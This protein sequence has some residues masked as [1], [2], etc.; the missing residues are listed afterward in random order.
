MDLARQRRF[1]EALMR[2]REAIEVDPRFAEAH[3]RLGILYRRLGELEQ[4]REALSQ[5]LELS[6]KNSKFLYAMGTVFF[7][8][9]EY[10]RAEQVFRKSWS[11]DGSLNSLFSLGETLQRL[12]RESQAA[13]AWREYL[14][15]DADSV[16]GREASRR[17]EEL[18]AGDESRGR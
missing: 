15:R 10:K 13:D 4:A 6:P 1:P 3:A 12:G 7:D 14:R 5:S 11:L 8:L 17:L 16:W 2:L 18:K 9:E